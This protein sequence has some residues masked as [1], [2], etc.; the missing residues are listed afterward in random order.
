[1]KRI[2][3]TLALLFSLALPASA[4][5][6]Q[7]SYRAVNTTPDIGISNIGSSIA[8]HTIS[9]NPV[10]TVTVCA[11]K[12]QQSPDNSTWSDLIV[13]PNCTAAG[14][15]AVANVSANYVRIDPTSVT[16]T[17]GSYIL[18]SWNGFNTAPS[19]GGGVVGCTTAGGIL[20]ENGTPNTGTCDP[21]L[22]RSTTG[23]VS[24]IS[25]SVDGLGVTQLTD[26][27][28]GI[29]EIV[30]ENDAVTQESTLNF[31]ANTQTISTSNFGNVGNAQFVMHTDTGRTCWLGSTSGSTCLTTPATGGILNSD[32]PVTATSV[33]TGTSPPTCT[34][35]T[36]GAF[37]A[38]EGT[39][40]T[41][42]SSVDDLYANSTTH[43]LDAINNNLEQ[44]C[45]ATLPAT[46]SAVTLGSGTSLSAASLCTTAVCTAGTYQVNVFIDVTTACA[47]TGTYI[48][49]LGW[50]DDQGAKTG[51]STT[52]FIPIQGTG[53]T[54]ASGS[55]ALA[56]TN[57]YGQGTFTLRTT[58]AATGGLGSINF[59]TTST[60]CGSGGPAVGKIY[61]TVTRLSTL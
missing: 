2:L 10:G 17:P 13:V 60:A 20:F 38:N 32:S 49:W 42:A 35:G 27:G 61:L 34:V 19:G 57:N 22:A 24:A 48:V 43:C 51:S 36:A 26:E 6:G 15:S 12:L 40:P 29:G 58:G 52:T 37:C 39:A 28:G 46:P 25:L 50:T 7:R 55:L 53:A 3:A 4:Q 41:G 5:I 54:V 21:S 30:E 18:F 44:G 33:A 56:S 47:T 14:Q 1:M 16:L 59:G 45:V 31:D 11:G 8:W 23:G 9:W